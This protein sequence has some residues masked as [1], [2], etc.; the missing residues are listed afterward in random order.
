M[1]SSSNGAAAPAR[2]CPSPVIGIKC[3]MISDECRSDSDCPRSD[4][5]SDSDCNNK[6]C[7]QLCGHKCV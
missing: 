2:K 7:C 4:C 3:I 1:D 5:H 6:I